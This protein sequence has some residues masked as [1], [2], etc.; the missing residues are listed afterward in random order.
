MDQ[1]VGESTANSSFS[2]ILVLSFGGFSL[3]LAAVGLYGVLAYL[4]TQRTGEIGIRMALGA[5]RA[6]VLRLVLLDG[7]RPA[8]VGLTLGIAASAAASRLIRS[9]LYGTSPL[10]TTIFVSVVATLLVTAVAACLLPAWRA[11]RIEPMQALR[12]E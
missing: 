1:I 4:V 11:A 7:L 3:L 9:A 2:A 12:S 8:L 5:E 6:R 10:D